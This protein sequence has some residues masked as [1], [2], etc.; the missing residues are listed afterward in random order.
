MATT[1]KKE[2]KVSTTPSKDKASTTPS[3]DKAS[4]TAVKDIK[5]GY[6][7]VYGDE[8]LYGKKG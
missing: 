8:E 7:G 6:L 4:T 1:D 2:P 5:G 3:K